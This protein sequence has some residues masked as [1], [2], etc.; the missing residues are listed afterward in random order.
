MKVR[1]IWKEQR[2]GRCAPNCPQRCL[3][4]NGPCRPASHGCPFPILPA[5]ACLGEMHKVRRHERGASTEAVVSGTG[6]HGSE[7]GG[8]PCSGGR[9]RLGHG[10]DLVGVPVPLGDH[11]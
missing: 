1:V 6:P 8:S 10:S 2:E 11:G 7:L 9:A 5:W 3:C 4:I